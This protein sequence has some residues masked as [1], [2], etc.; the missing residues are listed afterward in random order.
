MQVISFRSLAKQPSRFSGF[1]TLPW[2]I[3]KAAVHEAER[4][5]TGLGF[6]A[7]MLSGHAKRTPE[8]PAIFNMLQ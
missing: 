1:S 6:T 7:T 4:C 8:H 5:A 3:P 2:Q